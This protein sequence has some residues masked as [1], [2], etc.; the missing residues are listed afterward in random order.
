MDGFLLTKDKEKCTGCGACQQICPKKAISMVLDE[1]KFVYPKINS[2]LCVNCGMC[3][4]ICPC[5]ERPEGYSENKFAFG[6][7][8]KDDEIR[9]ESTSGG[10]FSAIVLSFCTSKDYAIFGAVSNGLSVR[11]EY[12]TDINE[13]Y[14][15]RKSKY[16]QSMIDDSF[17]KAKEFLNAG[18][19]VVFSGTPCQIAG[20]SKFLNGCNIDN[21]LTVEVICEGV[22][23]PLYLDRYDEFCLKKYGSR[24]K[25]LDYRYKDKNK[26]DFQVMRTELENGTVIKKD[27]WFNPYWSIWLDHIMSRPSCYKCQYTT[28][29]RV[30]D[31]S[32]GDLWGV[33]LYCPELYGENRGSSLIICNTE[34][35][36][37]ALMNA[38]NL[39]YGHELKFEDALKYQGPMRRSIP[40]N[41]NRKQFM[42]DVKCMEYTELCAK[43]S[44]KPSLKLLISK[45][46]WGNRQKV[47]LW[48]ITH[49]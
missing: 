22:P 43:W 27:R 5:E 46:I 18:K 21:L 33:H 4:K 47:K 3:H 23:S 49:R 32:L 40:Y 35:G 36:K 13:L 1:E 14:K 10:A 25:E 2:E 15:F 16:T 31:I 30:A 11:H 48:N 17:I 12:I 42:E 41:D 37:L 29:N 45:Y 19:T 7:Y 6:G 24:I 26:W 39:L 20:L 34:K 38:K 9:N 44:T 28:V 8:I